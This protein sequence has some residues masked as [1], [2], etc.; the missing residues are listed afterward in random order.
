MTP[1]SSFLYSQKNSPNIKIKPYLAVP[2][3]GFKFDEPKKDKETAN[4]G[5]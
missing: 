4:N 3:E 2:I 1:L 5:I